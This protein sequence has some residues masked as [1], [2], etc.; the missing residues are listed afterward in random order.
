MVIVEGEQAALE[1]SR[2]LSGE[3]IVLGTAE[4]NWG[5]DPFRSRCQI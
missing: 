1:R 4:R 2:L 5:Q 3:L